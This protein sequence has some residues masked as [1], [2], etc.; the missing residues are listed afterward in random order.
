MDSD[1]CP[2]YRMK[3]DLNVLVHLQRHVL[4]QDGLEAAALRSDRVRA[5]WQLGEAVFTLGIRRCCQWNPMASFRA[6]TLV[7]ATLAPDW[8]LTLPK[9]DPVDT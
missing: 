9:M 7:L 8:S 5:G 1:A 6:S 3:F 2:T 4:L